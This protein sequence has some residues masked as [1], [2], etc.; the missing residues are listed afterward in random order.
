MQRRDLLT[1]ATLVIAGAA[2][3]NAVASG[4]GGGSGAAEGATL[5]VSGVGLPVIADGRVRNYVFV[6]ITLHL[7]PTAV[8]ETL[9]AK[10]AYFR[11]ALV[12]TAHRAPFTVAG[13]WTRLNETAINAAMMAIAGV[14]AGPG[15]VVRS[16]VASQT[17][18]RRTGMLAA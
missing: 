1:A 5:T 3:S 17:P 8:P 4:G 12:R 15:A 10:D 13:D 11:D 7:G 16:E 2:A 6:S 18:R 14:V 9:R